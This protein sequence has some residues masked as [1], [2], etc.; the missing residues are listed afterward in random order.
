MMKSCTDRASEIA[1]G[2]IVDEVLAPGVYY[3]A[4]DGAAADALGR[5]TFAF[6]A[7][8]V[9]AQEGACR[10]P[11]TLVDGQTVSGTTVN[12]GDKFTT[13]CAGREDQQASADRL[14]KLTLGARAKVKLVLTTPTWDGVLAIRKSC[15]DPPRSTLARTNE[16]ACNNDFQDT[17]HAKIEAT[18]EAGTYFVVVDGHLARNEGAYTLELKTSKP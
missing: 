8:D 11:P 3:L 5:Y 10:A 1:C 7:R 9:S 4:V 12:A 16:A 13:S 17:R 14:Y 15:L 6:L 18:L 2:P